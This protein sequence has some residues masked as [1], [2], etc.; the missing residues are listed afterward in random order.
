MKGQRER[1]KC[2]C[3]CVWVYVGVGVWVCVCWA[4]ERNFVWPVSRGGSE[5]RF[6]RLRW[7]F[8][9][10]DPDDACLVDERWLI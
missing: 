3:M 10:Y 1:V 6:D 9:R 4:V 7:A 8:A 2:C 5:L